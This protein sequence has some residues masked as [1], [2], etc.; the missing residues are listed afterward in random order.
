MVSDPIDVI[1]REARDVRAEVTFDVTPAEATLL[2]K[3]LRCMRDAHNNGKFFVVGTSDSE[4]RVKVLR[5][6]A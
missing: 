1:S 3:S 4:H 5:P 6:R 2:Y